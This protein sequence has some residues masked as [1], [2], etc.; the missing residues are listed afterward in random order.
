MTLNKEQCENLRQFCRTQWQDM[1]TDE[2]EQW[3]TD[4]LIDFV[5]KCATDIGLD[6]QKIPQNV[7]EEI[8]KECYDYYQQT[9]EPSMFV[10]NCTE[11]WNNLPGYAKYNWFI[12]GADKFIDHCAVLFGYEPTEEERDNIYVNMTPYSVA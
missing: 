6:W 7:V 1:M 2:Q 3:L 10:L 4:G 9:T 11:I 12:K 5:A 8:C